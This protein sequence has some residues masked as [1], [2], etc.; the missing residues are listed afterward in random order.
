MYRIIKKKPLEMKEIALFEMEKSAHLKS[1]E[2]NGI[3]V[4]F[5][6]GVVLKI[7]YC[8]KLIVKMSV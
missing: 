7:L 1:L 4:E 3:N 6:H 8:Q 2:N 5:K